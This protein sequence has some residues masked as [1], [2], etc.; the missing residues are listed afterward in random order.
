LRIDGWKDEFDD[1]EEVYF[2]CLESEPRRFKVCVCVCVCV[3]GLLTE[4]GSSR[5]NVVENQTEHIML[6]EKRFA[7][8]FEHERL[9][10]GLGWVVVGLELP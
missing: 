2:D 4:R 3:W 5:G 10:K 1:E 8:R 7:V 9:S 6:D